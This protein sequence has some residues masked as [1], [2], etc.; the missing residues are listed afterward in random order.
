M[1]KRKKRRARERARGREGRREGE[2][3]GGR[4]RGCP[5]EPV[6][7]AGCRVR[8]QRGYSPSPP[9]RRP[10]PPQHFPS[11]PRLPLSPVPAAPPRAPPL[12]P[13]RPVPFPVPPPGPHAYLGSQAGGGQQGAEQR[14]SF[15][16]LQE[17]ERGGG[18]QGPGPAEPNFP[19]GEPAHHAA[20]GTGGPAGVADAPSPAPA[21]W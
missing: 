1:K 14:E 6:P 11:P 10:S 15:P 20:G 16:D 21:R 2:G 18:E 19:P 5:G 4:K 9:P 13:P 8:P 7:A 12:S 17:R 3:E